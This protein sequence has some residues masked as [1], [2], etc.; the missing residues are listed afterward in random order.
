M[1]LAGAYQEIDKRLSRIDFPLLFRGFHRFPFALYD[2]T[3]AYFDGEMTDK[4]AEFLGNTSVLFRGMHTAI[5]NLAELTMDF[6]TLTAKIVHEMLHAYQ[7]SSGETRWADERAALVKYRY[8]AANVSAR[9]GE[10]D[11]MEKCLSEYAPETFTRLLALR[12]ARADRFPYAYDYESRIEQIEGSAHFVELAALAQLDPE[13]AASCWERLFSELS[14]PARRRA[15]YRNPKRGCVNAWTIGPGKRG[16]AS[17][18]RSKR[19]SSF[20]TEI[21]VSSR[22]TYMTR[23]GTDSMLCCPASS[24]ISK[25]RRISRQTKNCFP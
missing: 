14:D 6:D 23:F 15:L 19:A 4:P 3:R 1:D 16:N 8:E 5:W 10:A 12:R 17:K 7:N 13:K 11:A 18:K 2:E 21:T 20:W 24:A 25:G 22:L 9:L